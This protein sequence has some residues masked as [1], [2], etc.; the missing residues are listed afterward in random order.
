[1]AFNELRDAQVFA[2]VSNTRAAT[3]A[4]EINGTDAAN[5]ISPDLTFV[6]TQILRNDFDKIPGTP[7]RAKSNVT[8]PTY[9]SVPAGGTSTDPTPRNG[10]LLYGAGLTEDNSTDAEISSWTPVATDQSI[11]VWTQA[12][13]ILTSATGVRG[14]IAIDISAGQYPTLTFTGEGTYVAPA[15]DSASVTPTFPT[16]DLHQAASASFSF[17]PSGG[18][19][20]TDLVV[21][22]FN[23]SWNTTQAERLDINS[24]NG[25]AGTVVTDRVGRVSATIE[26]EDGVST[27][28]PES[29]LLAGATHSISLEIGDFTAGAS[30][31]SIAL[32]ATAAQI[33]GV[34]RVADSGVMAANVDFLLTGATPFTLSFK[35]ADDS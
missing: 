6:E 24:A 28:N 2:K 5:V 15:A 4:I 26:F 31:S 18:A 11:F 23:F 32:A 3:D 16:E 33:T 25:Y 34:S 17:T 14:G 9:L 7:G 1:M 13:G 8:I 22:N 30:G 20:K 35:T 27:W 10:V 12:D 19:A 21:R 29:L